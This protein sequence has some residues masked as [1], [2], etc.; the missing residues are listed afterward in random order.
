MAL[1]ALPQ[2]KNAIDLI[3]QRIILR[4]RKAIW[5]NIRKGFGSELLT[6]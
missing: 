4:R 3:G 6:L 2:C 1:L 5:P